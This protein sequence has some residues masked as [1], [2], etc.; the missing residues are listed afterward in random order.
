M[1]PPP[2]DSKPRRQPKSARAPR[3][4]RSLLRRFVRGVLGGLLAVVVLVVLIGGG[5]GYVAYE[6]FSANLPDVD[7]LRNYQ[8]R[9]HEPRLRRRRATYGGACDRTAHF[10]ADTAI[11]DMVKQAFVSA[12]DQNF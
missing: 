12:E 5:A 11:P 8:P 7:G 2:N 10:R 9:G 4:R 3:P 1:A 6:R